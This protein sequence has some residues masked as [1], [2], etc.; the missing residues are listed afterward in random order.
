MALDAQPP[1]Q[2]SRAFLSSG[3][4]VL[5]N[6]WSDEA[7][8]VC[9]DCGEQGSG[10]RS[11]N[12]PNALHGHA[13]CLATTA[14]LGG[15][16]LF[17]DAGFY[18]YNSRDDW[19][20][21]FRRTE[22]HNT[23]RVDGRDQSC[24]LGKMA[25]CAC[26]RH[27][28]ELW[29]V[30]ADGTCVVGSHDGYARAPS[31]IVHRRTVWLRPGGYLLIHDELSGSGQH[32]IDLHFQLPPISARL[33]GSHGLSAEGFQVFWFGRGHMI[34]NLQQG[35]AEPN[36]GWVAPSLGVRCAAP[37]LTLTTAFTPPRTAVLT[38]AADTR[39]VKDVVSLAPSPGAFAEIKVH[40]DT[41]VD[42]IMAGG[43]GAAVSAVTDATLAVWRTDE[44]QVTRVARI[45][46][47]YARTDLMQA[48]GDTVP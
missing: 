23:V 21:H 18:S 15:K 24:H 43:D 30:D 27:R 34:S 25:W 6:E 5:R 40:A 38:L 2:T 42:R 26:P 36:Q 41:F 22:A 31:G 19:E 35:G 4:F 20:D 29:R 47:T 37:A 45:G 44:H 16:A 1:V 12:V 11:D 32:R 46:G 17:I 8:Y 14:F 39:R 7:D 28:L 33:A 9:F 10:A 13:D 48:S 3:V